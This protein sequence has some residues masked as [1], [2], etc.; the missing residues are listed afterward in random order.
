MKPCELDLQAASAAIKERSLSPVELVDSCLQRLEEV[1]PH[2][3][4]FAHVTAGQA[5]E[6]ARAAEQDIVA[7][8]Y[9]G[10]LHG[11]PVGVKDLY[12][13]AG[14]AS[15]CSSRVRAGR[16]PDEDSVVVARLREAGAVLLGQTHTHEFAY[17]GITPTTRNPWRTDRIPGGS[18]GGSAAAVAAGICTV[19]TGTDTAGSIRIPSALCGTIGL[20]STYGRVS[21]RGITP[22]SWSLDHAGAITRRVHDAAVALNAIAGYDPLDPAS[23]D[24]PVP[25]YT[26]GLDDGVKGLRIGVAGNF[27]FDH[28]EESVAEAVRQ[29]VSVLSDLGAQAGPVEIPHP[30]QILGTEWA[31]MMSEASSYHQESLRRSAD[32]YQPDVRAL[33]EAGELIFATDYIKALRVRQIMR[34][35]WNALFENVDVIVTPT[36][37]GAAPRVDQQESHWPDGVVE[38]I[39]MTLVRLTCQTNLTGLPALSIPVGFDA[40]NLPLAMQII[41][42]PFDEA[43][44]LRVGQAYEKAADSVGR[45][46]R[47]GG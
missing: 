21:R 46:A 47:P 26:A 30:D 18:S 28:V 12:D 6:A 4:S 17:G 3:H 32:L 8:R 38:P 44:V 40:D 29:A 7:G 27:Y 45:I 36:M 11:I 15:T 16:I 1:E 22:L 13:T 39:V 9:R 24:R 33:L 19:A 31:I 37:P 41:G 10:P 25:D 5:R 34:R 35:A 2:I 23:V 42:R 14:V 20:K 43:T